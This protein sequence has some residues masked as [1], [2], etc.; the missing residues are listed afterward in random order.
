MRRLAT[1]VLLSSLLLTGCGGSDTET[2]TPAGPGG[3]ATAGSGATV[4]TDANGCPTAATRSF[5]KTRFAADVGGAAFLINRYL[6]QP[7]SA[8]KFQQGANGRT[9]ALVKAAAA[10]AASAKLLK[11]ATENA[12]A[13]PTLCKTL[14]GPLTQ[15]STTL[16]SLTGS[17][18]NGTFNPALLGGLGGAV[19]GLIGKAEQAGI[20][21]EQKDPGLG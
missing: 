20:P 16:D 10:A 6:Y 21:I 12:K 3:A 14:A 11:N 15:L 4:G 13:D 1:L 8:G 17:L 19:S 9:V 5:A 2:V 18:R 7:Y